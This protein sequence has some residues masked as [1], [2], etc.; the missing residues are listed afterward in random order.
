MRIDFWIYLILHRICILLRPCLVFEHPAASSASPRLS[1]TRA[2][3][4]RGMQR[5]CSK[6]AGEMVF[7]GRA[8]SVG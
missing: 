6:Q 7:D 5:L 1:V 2:R 3:V 4:G 8:K